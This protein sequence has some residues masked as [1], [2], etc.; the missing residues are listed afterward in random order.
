MKTHVLA[1]AVVAALASGVATA[2]SEGADT[3]SAVQ[4]V[5]ESTYSGLQPAIVSEPA[6]ALD[7][8]WNGSEGGDTW[9]RF[10]ASGEPTVRQAS[11][12]GVIDQA[13]ATVS[14]GSEGG[15]T[16]SRFAPQTDV[17]PT[18]TASLVSKIR[19]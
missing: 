6:A 16:W 14:S 19:L 9:S 11:G 12:G 3:W 4:P 18:T 15:D 2:A 5:Q 1:A 13:D 7:G 8:T 17:R 10:S